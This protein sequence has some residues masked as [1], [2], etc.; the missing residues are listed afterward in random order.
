MIVKACLTL[1]MLDNFACFFVVCRFKKKKKIKKKIFQE[2]H[3]YQTVWVQIR[4]DVLL[5]LIWVQT[6]CKSYQ[7]S[8]KVAIS[9][10]RVKE[11]RKRKKI[12]M[13]SAVI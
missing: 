9:R 11:E 1:S 13:L 7:Q 3:Q 2:Y 6:V 5:G 10:E 8:I 4:P 12:K